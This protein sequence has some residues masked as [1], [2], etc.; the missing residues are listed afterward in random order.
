VSGE[1][2]ENKNQDVCSI[3]SGHTN[4]QVSSEVLTQSSYYQCFRYLTMRSF[5]YPETMHTE[6]S[7]APHCKTNSTCSR[8]K[9]KG[10]YSTNTRECLLHPEFKG[11][12]QIPEEFVIEFVESD[13]L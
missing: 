1:V 9:L 6:E 7:T 2:V 8:C 10:H 5:C 13:L 3:M 4:S 11:E 12:E